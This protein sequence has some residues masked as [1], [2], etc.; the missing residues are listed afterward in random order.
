VGASDDIVAPVEPT[1]DPVGAPVIETENERQ[2]RYLAPNLIT[3]TSLLFGI[4]SIAASY[5]HNWDL[6]GWMIIYSVLCDRLDGLVARRLHATSELGM[7]LDSLAD[8]LNFGL[9][10]PFMLYAF[11]CS[12]PELPFDDGWERPYLLAA[13]AIW[14]LAAG[15]RLARFNVQSDDKNPT[16][17]Y[18]GVP[19]TLAG[20][21]LAIWF[22]AFLKYSVAGHT[23]GGPKIFGDII[24]PRAVWLWMP[25]AIAIGGFLMASTVRMP[26][27]G[28]TNSR[29]LTAFV[30]VMVLFGYVCGFARV[31]PE[32]MAWQPTIWLVGF[33]VA[34]IFSE[35]LRSLEPPPL[36]PRRSS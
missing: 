5:H 11:L 8:F 9:A 29:G 25:A 34:G 30:L 28:R 32:L 17:V 22:L 7:Q 4:T 27:V 33:L 10:P 31:L 15:F 14:V 2:I 20:G 21:T 12:R 24:T 3:L 16:K 6:A 26:K 13:C 35:R 1:M 36:F 23:F 18:F 19:T